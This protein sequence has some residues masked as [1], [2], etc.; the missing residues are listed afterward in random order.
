M[1]SSNLG[2]YNFSTI[3]T[4]FS[5]NIAVQLQGG[6]KIASVMVVNYSNMTVNLYLNATGI[7]GTPLTIQAYK[8]TTLVLP[9]CQSV[10]VTF[11]GQSAAPTDSI[12][13]N[14]TDQFL[15]SQTSNIAAPSIAASVPTPFNSILGSYNSA[16]SYSGPAFSLVS[17]GYANAFFPLPTPSV[18]PSYVYV[19]D[20]I[21]VGLD[22]QK[23]RLDFAFVEIFSGPVSGPVLLQNYNKGD[24]NLTGVN[25]RAIPYAKTTDPFFPYYL[26]LTLYNIG[27]DIIGTLNFELYVAGYVQ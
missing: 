11:S 3:G 8:E 17:S 5:P 14:F 23:P 24:F 22:R 9:E 16:G 27:S 13:L 18:T 10:F 6:A 4:V 19:T 20:I 2:P 7:A 15:T 21:T 25:I 26:P 12:Y 1:A